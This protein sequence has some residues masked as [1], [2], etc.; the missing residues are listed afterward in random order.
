MTTLLHS[1]QQYV[2]K[3]WLWISANI[4]AL[5]PLLWLVWDFAQGNLSVNLI[6]DITDRTGKAA[7]ILLMLSLACTPVNI[8]FGWSQV[9]TVRKALGLYAFFYASGHFL[10][11]VG[12]D[13]GFDVSF[14]LGDALLEKPYILVGL[15]ALL[16]LLPLAITSTKGWMKRLGRNWKRLH[17][18]VYG[19]GV[20][21]VLH[22]FWLAKAAERLEPL[23]YGLG[24]TLLLIVRIPPV[25]RYL[26]GLRQRATKPPARTGE[27][28][29]R[30]A[31]VRSAS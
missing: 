28:K 17:Q 21:A 29:P 31:A 25:R 3:H 30:S 4:G 26:T 13:Y 19:A 14:I 12:L 24:L 23:L 11:F 27:R 18:L 6:D 22:F 2:R 7:L 8:L 10:N 9:L 20:L 15:G 1:S 5:I 16:I